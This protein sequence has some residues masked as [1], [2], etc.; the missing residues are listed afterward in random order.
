MHKVKASASVL[1]HQPMLLKISAAVELAEVAIPAVAEHLP[2]TKSTCRK[3][4][5]W[6]EGPCHTRISSANQEVDTGCIE[7]GLL[8]GKSSDL[9][10]VLAHCDCATPLEQEMCRTALHPR[11]TPRMH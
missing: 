8:Q 10:K 5:T 7:K 3:S 9:I 6:R 11:T 1:R 2:H 4:H